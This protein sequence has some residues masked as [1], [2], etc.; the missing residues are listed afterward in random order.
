[1]RRLA[2]VGVGVAL[3]TGNASAQTWRTYVT[4]DVGTFLHTRNAAQSTIFQTESL[5]VGRSYGSTYGY[6]FAN[7]FKTEIEGLLTDAASER[8]GGLAASATLTTTR[9]TLKSMYEFIDGAWHMKPYV[10][11]GYGVMD[12]NAHVLGVAGDHWA[13]AYQLRSGIALGFTQKLVGSLEYRWTD[14][15][16][17]SF[18][19]AGIPTKLELDRHRFVVGMNY[20]Y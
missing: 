15:S 2:I 16:K 1:M 13:T 12:L 8:L 14:G 7:G 6:D 19:L 20:K 9:V 18:S 17:P 3:L 11:V 5:G 10:G 4:N